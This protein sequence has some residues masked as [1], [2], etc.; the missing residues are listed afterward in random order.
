MYTKLNIVLNVWKVRMNILMMLVLVH[1][2]FDER[3]QKE[4]VDDEYNLTNRDI[5]G[6]I[7]SQCERKQI[8]LIQLL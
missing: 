7:L 5:F 1:E 4:S 6:I 8:E 3:Q 2:Y